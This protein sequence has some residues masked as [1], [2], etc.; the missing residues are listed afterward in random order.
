MKTIEFYVVETESGDLLVYDRPMLQ[1]AGLDSEETLIEAFGETGSWKKLHLKRVTGKEKTEITRLCQVPDPVIGFQ[2]DSTREPAARIAV[3]VEQ[4]EGFDFPP[5]MKAHDLLDA[6]LL[7]A[8][9]NALQNHLYPNPLAN[10][11][12]LKAFSAHGSTTPSENA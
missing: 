11:A 2:Y 12:F 6:P 1:L 4:W 10:A 7:D 8:I 5:D 9:L 3:I